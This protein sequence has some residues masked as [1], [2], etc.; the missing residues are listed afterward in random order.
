MV[1]L[2]FLLSGLPYIGLFFLEKYDTAFGYSL[3]ILA[4]MFSILTSSITSVLLAKFSPLNGAGKVYSF[5]STVSGIFIIGYNYLSGWMI[6]QSFNK[7]T[8][9]LIGLIS[10]WVSVL[11]LGIGMCCPRATL[12][13]KEE[14]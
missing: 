11:F 1:P 14:E 9:I 13:P 2:V 5:K 4:A 6:D 7:Y 10:I 3:Q 8:F 12:K